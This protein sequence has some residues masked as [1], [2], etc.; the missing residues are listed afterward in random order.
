MVSYDFGKVCKALE[1]A[2]KRKGHSP[3]Q[4]SAEMG[5]SSVTY[6]NYTTKKDAIPLKKLDLI[7]E[8]AGIKVKDVIVVV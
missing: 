2:R 4:A 5:F 3:T 8:Y 1:R 6:Y 7:C